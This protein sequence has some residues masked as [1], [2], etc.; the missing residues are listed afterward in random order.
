L[1]V[2][3]EEDDALRSELER[4]ERRLQRERD[5]RI[6]AELIAEQATRRL[7]ESDRLKTTFLET[8]S[9][10][11]RTP[12]ASITG[13]A[14]L[15]AQDWDAFDDERRLDFVRR[16]QRNGLVLESLIEQLLDFTLLD[17]DDVTHPHDRVSLTEQV[18]LL[19]E[20]LEPALTGRRVDLD[21]EANVAATASPIALARIVTNLLMN[22][23]NYAGDGTIFVRVSQ[24]EGYAVL[25]VADEGPGVPPAE[26]SHIFERFYRGRSDATMRVHGTGLG[27][28]LVKELAEQTGG[29]VTV[30][31]ADSGGALFSVFLP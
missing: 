3:D 25:E 17:R 16:I 31:D 18:P 13:F 19:I 12:L 8:V 27:L 22:A 20:Q 29:Y 4:V 30:G 5:T 10:E 23:K 14:N 6:E 26:R 7:Y 28:A 2:T 9:H 11:L 21:I 1:T 24:R 15:L